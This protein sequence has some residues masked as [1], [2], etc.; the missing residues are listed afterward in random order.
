MKH[1]QKKKSVKNRKETPRIK[2][3]EIQKETTK[4][5]AKEKAI[6]VLTVYQERVHRMII[7]S[8]VVRKITIMLENIP[9]GMIVSSSCRNN[10]RIGM[11]DEDRSTV[12]PRG[13]YLRFTIGIL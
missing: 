2:K 5:L 8:V 9:M 11:T 4:R 10:S 1:R 13:M 6:H 3:R 7:I 12:L